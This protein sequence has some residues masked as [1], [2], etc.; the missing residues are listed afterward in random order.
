MCLKLENKNGSFVTHLPK[1]KL[2]QRLDKA[3]DG[4]ITCW[5]VYWKWNSHLSS[6]VMGGSMGGSIDGP[7]VITSDRETKAL[8]EQEIEDG[9]IDYGIHV[10]TSR[11]EAYAALEYYDEVIVP[12]ICR[13]ADFV[14]QGIHGDAVFMKIRIRSRDW[15]RLFKGT[16]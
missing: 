4:E 3:K 10:Y 5:K 14:A 13:K 15:N 9:M 8:T 12:V 1:S 11:E 7:G 6:V 16:K 2:M